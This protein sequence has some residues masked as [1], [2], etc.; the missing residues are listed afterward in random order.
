[1]WQTLLLHFYKTT[2]SMQG[3]VV[4]V[5]EQLAG[6]CFSCYHTWVRVRLSVSA[7]TLPSPHSPAS[8]LDLQASSPFPQSRPSTTLSIFSF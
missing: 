1:M 4:E 3:K 7:F 8:S 5:R 2:L 6:D